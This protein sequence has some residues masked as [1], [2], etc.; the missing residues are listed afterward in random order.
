MI[1]LHLRLSLFECSLTQFFW[2][3]F[4]MHFSSV[5]YLVFP[6]SISF[7]LIKSSQRKMK[8][9]FPMFNNFVLLSDSIFQVF[10]TFMRC[11]EKLLK[12]YWPLWCRSHQT[13]ASCPTCAC[14]NHIGSSCFCHVNTFNFL[15]F[16][17][18]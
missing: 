9:I 8:A 2:Q 14:V 5:A 3:K 12:V 6:L 10:I 15:P 1:L 16:F 13:V 7:F 18:G 17:T 4:R 11:R